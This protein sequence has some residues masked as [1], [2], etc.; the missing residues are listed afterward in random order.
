MIHK[1]QYLAFLDN[2]NY[3]VYTHIFLVWY[4]IGVCWSRVLSEIYYHFWYN[5]WNFDKDLYLSIYPTVMID[6]QFYYY[7]RCILFNHNII[8][9]SID[10]PYIYNRASK[11]D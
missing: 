7:H 1:H 5:D 11:S 8:I 6:K 4:A 2:L 3:T 9:N 10:Y